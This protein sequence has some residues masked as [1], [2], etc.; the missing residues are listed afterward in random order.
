MKQIPDYNGSGGVLKLLEFVDKFEAFREGSELSPSLELQLATSKLTRDALIWW[1]QHRKEFLP[2]SNKRIKDF[3][4][5][6]KGLLEQFTLPEYAKT[7]CT[8]LRTLRQTGRVKDY[9]A[10]FNCLIQQLPT[11]SFEETS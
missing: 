10:S 6:Q 7:I 8:K 9:N 4:Q 5:L 2:S 11:T 3:D 1:R